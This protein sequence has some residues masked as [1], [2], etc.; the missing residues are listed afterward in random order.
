MKISISNTFKLSLYV[1]GMSFFLISCEEDKPNDMEPAY[2]DYEVRMT[3]APGNFTEVNIHI[4]KVSVHNDIDGWIDL[5]TNAGIYNLLEFANG[6]DTVIAKQSIPSGKV[7]QIRFLLG[8]SNSVVVDGATHQLQVPSA[9]SSGYKLLVN[10]DL[11]R[12]LSY[13]VLVDFDAAKSIVLTGNGSYKLKPVLKVVAE[14]VDGAIK[15]DLDPNAVYANIYA[16]KGMDTTGA[17]PNSDG[18]F[19]INALDTGIYDVYIN[20]ATP[21]LA[22]TILGVTVS[23]GSVTDLGTITLQQ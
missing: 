23:K 3:D 12:G 17:V 22:D 16:I 19:L 9:S 15:G 14:G 4:L 6:V 8:D 10:Q 20:P 11:Y 18:N 7:S 2:S 5:N 21:Y 13:S 1:L